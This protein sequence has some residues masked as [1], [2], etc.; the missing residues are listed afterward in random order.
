MSVTHRARGL[1][2]AVKEIVYGMTAFEFERQ[3]MHARAELEDLFILVTM[4]D[5]VGVPILPPYYSLR[6]VPYMV[7][8][9]E[10]WKRRVLRERH[11]LDKEEFDL[12]EM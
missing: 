12:I 5:L 7:P 3:A 11:A 2:R 9:T 10:A 4:G 8:R 6:L 1:L